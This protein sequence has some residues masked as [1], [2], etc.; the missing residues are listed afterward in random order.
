MNPGMHKN[1]DKYRSSKLFPH[2]FPITNVKFLTVQVH[3]VSCHPEHD[4]SVLTAE[5]RPYTS[6]RWHSSREVGV[7]KQLVDQS[8]ILVERGRTSHRRADTC[9][10]CTASLDTGRTSP[11]SLSEHSGWSEG[12][13]ASRRCHGDRHPPS[14]CDTGSK[15]VTGVHRCRAGHMRTNKH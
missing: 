8:C 13:N 1:G 10:R 11:K 14:L 3:Q 12:S 7:Q 5:V 4:V 2:H 6:C 15:H 9:H